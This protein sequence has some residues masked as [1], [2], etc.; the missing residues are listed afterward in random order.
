[1]R[2]DIFEN[3]FFAIIICHLKTDAKVTV[4]VVSII[5]LEIYC[6]LAYLWWCF[7]SCVLLISNKQ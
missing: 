1:M 2:P 7:W 5:L 4:C 6:V 3:V